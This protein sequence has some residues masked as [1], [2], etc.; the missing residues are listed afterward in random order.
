MRGGW[1]WRGHIPWIMDSGGWRRGL[2]WPQGLGFG[3]G[4]RLT[5][6]V[7]LGPHLEMELQQDLARP[8]GARQGRLGSHLKTKRSGACVTADATL[9]CKVPGPCPPLSLQ[10]AFL[11]PHKALLLP[12]N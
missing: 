7:R 10:P 2:R 11:P 8:A 4:V 9:S 5:G 1:A 12:M 3:A 6:A